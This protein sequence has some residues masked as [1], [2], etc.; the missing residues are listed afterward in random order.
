MPEI[1][2]EIPPTLLTGIG[3]WLMGAVFT[4]VVIMQGYS[5]GSIEE[6]T[7]I[8]VSALWPVFSPIIVTLFIID[9]GILCVRGL[10]KG[11][12]AVTR[13]APRRQ[14]QDEHRLSQ[15]DL[16]RLAASGAIG[17]G[18]N[19]GTANAVVYGPLPSFSLTI[20]PAAQQRIHDEVICYF[21]KLIW[22]PST[23][24]APP[25]PPQKGSHFSYAALLE[26]FEAV[27]SLG[28]PDYLSAPITDGPEL[29]AVNSA[30]KR[31]YAE[32]REM[33]SDEKDPN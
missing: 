31:L 30:L 32:R 16:M 4:R 19:A 22:P 2:R 7:R 21:D 25:R 15:D 9:I 6:R 23:P 3:L 13:R 29:A 18:N 24:Y 26:L 27:E 20:K 1:I 8:F 17:K 5:W 28:S 33:Q 14:Q 12:S 11:W 10:C